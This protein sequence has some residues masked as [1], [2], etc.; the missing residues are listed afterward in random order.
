MADAFIFT[1]PYW[2]FVDLQDPPTVAQFTL[3]HATRRVYAP[4]RSAAANHTVLPPLNAQAIPFQKGTRPHIAADYK[5]PQLAVVPRLAKADGEDLGQVLCLKESFDDPID[6][7]PMDSLRIDSLGDEVPHD[8]IF[9]WVQDLMAWL[10]VRTSQWWIGH[11]VHPLQGLVRA[12]ISIDLK[13]RALS[14]P[15]PMAAGYGLRGDERPVTSE[16]SRECIDLA[17]NGAPPSFRHQL[18]LDGRYHVA[19]RDLRRG[20]LDLATA[21]EFAKEELFEAIWRSRA[22]GAYRRGR[23]ISGFDLPKHLGVDL[24]RFGPSLEADLPEVY[25]DLSR[26]WAL[27]NQVAHGQSPVLRGHTGTIGLDRDMAHELAGAAQAVVEWIDSRIREIS[28]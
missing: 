22:G 1:F 24:A 5:S 11:S 20:V 9:P 18:L 25:S 28:V 8:P 26:L 19:S 12:S 17:L 6:P 14:R 15:N 16:I 3:G 21:C 2:V 13:G 27:R 10:R 23:L 4:F 7:F